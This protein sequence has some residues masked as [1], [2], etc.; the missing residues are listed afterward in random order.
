MGHVADKRSTRLAGITVLA[1]ALA[2]A[3]RVV[4]AQT[5]AEPATPAQPAAPVHARATLD[6]QAPAGLACPDR[7]AFASAI[8]TRVGYDAIVADAGADTKTLRVKFRVAKSA[9]HVTLQLAGAANA[10]EAEKSLVSESGGCADLAGAT[11]F[12]AAIGTRNDKGTK[13]VNAD[14]SSKGSYTCDGVCTKG[15]GRCDEEGAG[16]GVG[17]VDRKYTNG[18]GSFGN[19]VSSCDIS[20]SYASGNTTMTSLVCHCDGMPVVSDH[21]ERA[22]GLRG[23]AGGDRAPLHVRV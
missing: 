13:S 20:E 6:Y 8:A 23:R 19:R 14:I 10:I 18:S 3:P 17:W 21:D 7:D 5:P 4:A 15:G 22:E 11:A 12:A 1:L 16:N 2:L 9:V